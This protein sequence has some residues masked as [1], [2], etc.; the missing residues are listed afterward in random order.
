[1]AGSGTKIA[2]DVVLLENQHQ[3]VDYFGVHSEDWRVRCERLA[4]EANYEGFSATKFQAVM[5]NSLQSEVCPICVGRAQ[6]QA[7]NQGV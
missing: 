7:I 2:L 3:H 6:R 1:M 5:Q 4:G